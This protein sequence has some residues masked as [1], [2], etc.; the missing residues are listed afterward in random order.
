MIINKKRIVNIELYWHLIEDE[1][2]FYIGVND[3]NRFNNKLTQIGFSQNLELGETIL[4]KIVGPVTRFNAEGKNNKLKNLP[5]ETAYRQVMWK[6]KQFIGG[7]NFEEVEEVR[8]VPYERYQVEFIQPPSEELSIVEVD[9][10]KMVLSSRILKTEANSIKARN[11]F[12]IFFEIFGEC[13]MLNTD[14]NR[15]RLPEIQRKNWTVLPPGEYPFEAIQEQINHGL[16]A[17][18]NRNSRIIKYRIQKISSFEPNFIAIGNGGFTGYWIFGFPNN[19]IFLLESVYPNNAT[20]ALGE[21]WENI[22]RMTKSEILRNDFH[23]ARVVH[24][25]SWNEEIDRL[26]R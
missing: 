3:I 9:N 8:D 2:E 7:G 20:Y 4:P 25:L 26:L 15:L 1:N 12:N 11:I 10:Q 14:L 24:R 21:N 13:M 16:Q 18:N 22:S 23:I 19:N 6:W 5:K 17:V